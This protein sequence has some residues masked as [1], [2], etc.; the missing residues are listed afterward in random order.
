M[1]YMNPGFISIGGI[2][3]FLIVIIM[4]LK[5]G[6]DY[7]ENKKSYAVPTGFVAIA[8]VIA[9]ILYDGDS[10]KNKI[11]TNIA[12]FQKGQEL[13]CSTLSTTYLVSKPTGWRLHKDNF[14][15]DS[16]LLD[17]RYCEE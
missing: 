7:T 17:A 13:Q 11:D 15:K 6:R 14:T 16:I 12:Q 9:F 1:E 4:L 3:I 10:T 2:F 8:L 5:A